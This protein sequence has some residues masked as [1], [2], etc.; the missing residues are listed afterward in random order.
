MIRT[1]PFPSLPAPRAPG[2]V[3]GLLVGLAFAGCGAGA[4]FADET[5]Q[6][7]AGDPSGAGGRE[8]GAAGV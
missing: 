4:L 3:R 7:D 5:V 6:L 8:G 1:A 2:W